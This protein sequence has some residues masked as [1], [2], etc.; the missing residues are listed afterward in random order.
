MEQFRKLLLL[1]FVLIASIFVF[2]IPSTY[3]ANYHHPYTNVIIFGDSLSDAG[4]PKGKLSEPEDV[5]N[6]SW[7]QVKGKVGA[8][9]TNLDVKSNRHLLWVNYF[10]NQYFD[11]QN[12][13][14]ASH[15]KSLQL[16]PTKD[17]ISYAWASAETGLSYINDAIYPTPTFYA[18][19]DKNCMT[20]GPG[21]IGSKNACVPSVG[22]QI[23]RYLADVNNHPNPHTLFIIWAGGNDILNNVGKL[24]TASAHAKAS[25]KDKLKHLLSYL[26]INPTWSM[27]NPNA[28]SNPVLQILEA[29][30]RLVKAGVSPKQIYVIDLPDLS[31]TPAA[32]DFA[33]GNS[34]LLGIM[35]VVTSTYNTN[36]RI[37]LA[38]NLFNKANLPSSHI[39]SA[40]EVFKRVINDPLK[41]G[42]INVKDSCVD[43]DN[44]PYC[45]G[46]LFFDDKHPTTMTGKLMAKEFADFLRAQSQ[47]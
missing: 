47:V 13:Y 21:E 44:L 12:I 3:A 39:F 28:Y 45:K 32:V 38:Y 25:I 35:K 2:T 40:N 10:M 16:D 33:E 24:Y 18:H 17:S 46:Y 36:L 5:G 37:A 20:H 31:K 9:I 23:Q 29:K 34:L 22:L 4:N 30:D 41:Y 6:N 27:S 1:Q 15:V 26:S 19:N 11:G 43:K 8:P 42:F 7:V 14:P